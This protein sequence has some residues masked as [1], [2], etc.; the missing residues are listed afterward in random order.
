MVHAVT[1]A[2]KPIGAI[3]LPT[4]SYFMAFYRGLRAIM[5]A[6]ENGKKEQ[7]SATARDKNLTVVALY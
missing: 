6:N 3:L 7:E 5:G 1:R 2:Q 4:L